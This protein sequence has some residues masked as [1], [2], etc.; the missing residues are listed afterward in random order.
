VRPGQAGFTIFVD[1]KLRA[2]GLAGT[3]AQVWLDRDTIRIAGQRDT[4]LEIPLDSIERLRLG[5]EPGKRP[6]YQALIWRR[7]ARRALRL[8]LFPPLEGYAEAMRGIVAAL[9]VRR[10]TEAVELGT[11]G[12][13][14]LF[15]GVF[16]LLLLGA[17]LFLAVRSW[18][19]GPWPIALAFVLLSL[20]MAALV[21]E[22]ARTQRPRPLRSLEEV[23]QVLPMLPRNSI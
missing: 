20:L 1:R 4:G 19:D 22:I 12:R 13:A 5:V 10:G 3:A 8:R 7:G 21:V 17:Y 16:F 2:E 14:A 9:A 23:E 15:N 18:R 11:T 6:V